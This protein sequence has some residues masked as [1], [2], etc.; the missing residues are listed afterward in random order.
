MDNER[1]Y[2][3]PEEN[4][5]LIIKFLKETFQNEESYWTSEEIIALAQIVDIPDELYMQ[6]NKKPH[7]Q[8][9]KPQF[10]EKM[11]FCFEKYPDNIEIMEMGFELLCQTQYSFTIEDLKQNHPLLAYHERCLEIYPNNRILHFFN[12]HYLC[13]IGEKKHAYKLFKAYLRDTD[14]LPIII[15]DVSHENV[16][17]IVDP[18]FVLDCFHAIIKNQKLFQ[19]DDIL[20]FISVLIENEV[21]P[22]A[23]A[24]LD[25]YIGKDPYNINYWYFLGILNAYE[26]NDE[27]AI[28][29]FTMAL[30]IDP[31]HELV[32]FELGCFYMD[33]EEFQKAI[34]LFLTIS[35]LTQSEKISE[36]LIHL[37]AAYQKTKNFKKA[38]EYFLI[39]ENKYAEIFHSLDDALRGL[40]EILT[41][42]KNFALAIS[43]IKKHID[44]YYFKWEL[45]LK[46]G[47]LEHE[48][49]NEV[50]AEE[51]YLTALNEQPNNEG[52]YKIL[53]DFYWKTDNMG[54][55]IDM[56]NKRADLVP[57]NA[58][59]LYLLAVYEII[60]K[61]FQ[62]GLNH[63]QMALMLDYEAHTIVF[64]YFQDLNQQKMLFKL[65]ETYKN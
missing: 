19:N 6:Y 26:E 8:Y 39:V 49:G 2:S 56:A 58:E 29:A 14:F 54:M 31:N 47:Y 15:S 59:A 53:A 45:Y 52:L 44:R 11:V 5:D 22:L 27:E 32:N 10:I 12:A 20:S 41:E 13:R 36:Y 25:R 64:D 38:I 7:E 40:I 61:Q 18:N 51:A 17:G 1:D 33:L 43:F 48:M 9:W 34:P 55:A 16:D 63:M 3:F 24:D 65:I 23:I 28:E 60:D 62:T 57:E 46:L 21:G 4:N 42:Q 50:H 35:K 30:T 37:A